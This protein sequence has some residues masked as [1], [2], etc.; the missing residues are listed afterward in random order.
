MSLILFFFPLLS[1]LKYKF[2]RKIFRK[3]FWM[4]NLLP[5]IFFLFLTKLHSIFWHFSFLFREFDGRQQNSSI[6]FFCFQ[7]FDN[8][9][10]F[11]FF[12]L[13]QNSLKSEYG[14][15]IK[16]RFAP[17]FWLRFFRQ[18]PVMTWP[19]LTQ[20]RKFLLLRNRFNRTAPSFPLV[21]S[22]FVIN[23]YFCD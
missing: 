17:N 2:E 18:S 9:F 15:G 5:N 10:V 4:E 3:K 14:E 21:L 19:R 13:T 8:F 22:R 1:Q 11:F 20:I 6:I 16:S 12:C 7:K 23:Q